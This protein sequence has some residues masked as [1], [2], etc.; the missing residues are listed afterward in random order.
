MTASTMT[1]RQP[2]L[3]R[4]LEWD[5]LGAVVRP[6]TGAIDAEQLERLVDDV[7]EE[8]GQVTTTADLGRDPS[9]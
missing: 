3:G 9:E 7:V 6:E 5:V 8:A 1:A 4:Q 2:A